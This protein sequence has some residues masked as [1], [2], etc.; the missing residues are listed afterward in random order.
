[1]PVRLDAITVGH[2]LRFQ[3]VEIVVCL[4][5]HPYRERELEIGVRNGAGLVEHTLDGFLRP[6][7][8]LRRQANVSQ[9]QV[10]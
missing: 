5:E 2:L 1:M 10:E 4:A 9:E 8:V 6:R 7:S 3:G